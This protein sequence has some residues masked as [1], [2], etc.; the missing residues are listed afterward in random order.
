MARQAALVEEFIERTV[1]ARLSRPDAADLIT[2][3]DSGVD[4]TGL[5][6]EA[7]AIRADLEEM[8]AGR[9]LGR[10]SRAQML[11]A[12]DQGNARLAEIADELA[13]AAR[14]SVLA[15]LI[16]GD[17]AAGAWELLDLAR[18][19]A[20]IKTL[21]TITLH[22][23]GRGARRAFDPATVTVTWPGH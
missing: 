6:E 9:A 21:T 11:A 1:I 10:I 5:R 13:E 23:P 20:V 17:S 3:P 19:R 16:A 12:T 7:A 2:A 18:K 14:E 15:P 4:V 22:S 8:A